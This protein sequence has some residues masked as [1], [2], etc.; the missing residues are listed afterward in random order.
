MGGNIS[1][2]DDHNSGVRAAK[3]QHKGAVRGRERE[4]SRK[5]TESEIGIG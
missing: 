4:G 5:A 1:T 3:Q 2:K